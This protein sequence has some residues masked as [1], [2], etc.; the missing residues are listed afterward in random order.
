MKVNL[1]KWANVLDM[2]ESDKEMLNAF[3][4]FYEKLRDV[5]WSKPNDVMNTFNSADIINCKNSN[6]IVFNVGGNKYRLIT[7]YYFGKKLIN[8]Y[9]KFVGTH[10][11]YDKVDVCK[12]NMF[13]K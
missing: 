1:V 3:V 9:I 8:L 12:I 5:T 7:G 4:K 10:K 2:V 13:K 6:R 11:E